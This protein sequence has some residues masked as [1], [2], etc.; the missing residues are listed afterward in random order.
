MDAHS[1]SHIHYRKFVVMFLTRIKYRLSRLSDMMVFLALLFVQQ[2]LMDWWALP[3][4]VWVYGVVLVVQ[5]HGLAY[6]MI[7]AL[8]AGY[9]MET[10]S[11]APWGLFICSYASL[12]IWIH[13]LKHHLVWHKPLVRPVVY[14]LSHGVVSCLVMVAW[15]LMTEHHSLSATMMQILDI[16]LAW[17]IQSLLCLI[18]AFILMHVTSS[19]NRST[20]L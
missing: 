8:L 2:R 20:S 4:D 3:W 16:W 13:L 15:L 11:M 5:R 6:S 12:S 14:V 18:V 9:V 7:W 1:S 10:H 19:Y 17:L